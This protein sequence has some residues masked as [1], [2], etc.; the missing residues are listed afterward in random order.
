[1]ARI[2]V[3]CGQ[4]T[5]AAR[6]LDLAEQKQLV[7]HYELGFPKVELNDGHRQDQ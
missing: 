7:K 2:L 3:R 6:R 4:A 5:S 1:M